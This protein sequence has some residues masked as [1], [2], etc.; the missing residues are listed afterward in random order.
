MKKTLVAML[1]SVA[2]YA[3]ETIKVVYDLTT[4]D[5]ERFKLRMLSGVAKNMAHYEQAFKEMKV[6]VI[7]H[8]GA[9][10]F[11]LKDPAA[12]KYRDDPLLLEQ[13]DAIQ[14]RIK[15]LHE[16]YDVEF[17]MCDVGRIKH[18]IEKKEIL[19]FVQYV[20]NAAIGLI[21]KQQEGYAF[22]SIR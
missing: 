3:E 7:I 11:F 22:L 17:Y 13:A 9:Y 6:A 1:L 20:P 8:G 5:T 4:G 2:L 12:S 15:G 21:D 16:H 10:R 14:K 19:D 18:K